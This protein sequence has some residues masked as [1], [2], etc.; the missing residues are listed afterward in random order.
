MERTRL[1]AAVMGVCGFLVFRGLLEAGWGVDAAR[2][3]APVAG[4]A[5]VSD[6]YLAPPCASVRV[7]AFTIVL[8]VD[9]SRASAAALHHTAD[10]ARRLGARVVLAHALGHTAP[11]EGLAPG[12]GH[13]R[14]A[15]VETAH[16]WAAELRAQGVEAEVDARSGDAKDVIL[17][18]AAHH[19]ADLVVLGRRGAGR[20]R[21]LLMGSVTRAVL[22]QS[23]VPVT[24]VPLRAQG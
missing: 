7:E 5:G 14:L 9:F 24:V 19:G 21:R 22:A 8:A 17:S 12:A 15:A 16:E 4:A 10:L 13:G 20:A 2:A 6:G 18:S 11:E 3:A 23:T 1:A